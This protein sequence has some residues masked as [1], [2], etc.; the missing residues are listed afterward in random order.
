[1]PT[2]PSLLRGASV[3]LA[4]ALA[5]PSCDNPACVYSGNC[6]EGG[7]G[8]G[9]GLGEAAAT[10]PSDLT[11]LS[12]SAP[13]VQAFYPAGALIATVVALGLG[14]APESSWAGT[15]ALPAMSSLW[16]E[17]HVAIEPPAEPPPP[18]CGCDGRGAGVS[19]WRRSAEDGAAR[20]PA[21]GA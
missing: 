14:M 1:M 19:P 4:A 9:G 15:T 10:E 8:G 12:P 18:P 5:L 6:D 16:R 20:L 11:W 3:A 7:G 2:L 21:A 13:T 17:S